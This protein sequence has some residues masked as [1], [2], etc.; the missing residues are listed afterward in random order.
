M[1]AFTEQQ[2]FIKSWWPL[3][4]PG[5]LIGVGVPVFVGFEK[6]FERPELWAGSAVVLF[7]WALLFL[8]KLK[9]RVDEN[10]VSVTFIPLMRKP[11]TIL[12][13]DVSS[14]KVKEYDALGE[15]GGWGYRKGWKKAKRAYNIS[16]SKGLEL[17]LNDGSI[18]MVG[19]KNA[20]PLRQY[21]NYL[22]DKY[23]LA[24]LD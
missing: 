19:T 18:I 13:K 17:T 12:W 15:Y 7:V 2:S 8:L 3:L 24:S 14:A 10:G 22:K 20:E 6:G 16:G 4:I 11:K 1:D 5:L 21:L 9:T 23:Q